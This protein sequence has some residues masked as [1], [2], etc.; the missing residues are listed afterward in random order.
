M[1]SISFVPAH[2]G[3]DVKIFEDPFFKVRIDS[4][5]LANKIVSHPQ[6]WTKGGTN[7]GNLSIS[8]SNNRWPV[9]GFS[10]AGYTATLTKTITFPRAGFYLVDLAT[11]WY[12]T[13]TAVLT[14]TMDGVTLYSQPL[15][16]RYL[17]FG[18][19]HLQPRWYSAGSHTFVISLTGSGWVGHLMVYPITRYEGDN[20][21]N[22]YDNKLNIKTGTF[23][24]NGVSEL[25]QCSLTVDMKE[26]YWSAEGDNQL[27]IK[28]MD[29]LTLWLGETANDTKAMFGGY[30]GSTEINPGDDTLNITGVDRLFDLKRHTTTQTYTIGVGTGGYPSVYELGRYL[31]TTAENPIPTDGIPYVFGLY[32]DF[33]VASDINTITSSIWAVAQDDTKG[34]PATCLKVTKTGAGSAAYVWLHNDEN[35]PYDLREYP[36]LNIGYQHGWS[37]TLP[38]DMNIGITLYLTDEL[39]GDAVEYWL[40]WQGTVP[41]NNLGDVPV[42]GGGPWHS[43]NVNLLQLVEPLVGS[44]NYYVTKIRIY[45]P[46]TEARTVS[47]WFDQIMAYHSENQAMSYSATDMNNYYDVLN[48]LC[49][50]TSHI[51]YIIP[52]DSRPEDIMVIVPQNSLVSGGTIDEGNNLIEISNIKSD[53][54]GDNMVNYLGGGWTDTSSTP[55]TSYGGSW[56][57]VFDYGTISRIDSVEGATNSNVA[58]KYINDKLSSDSIPQTGF[59]ARVRGVPDLTPLQYVT[60]N[61][62]KWRLMGDYPIKSITYN[63]DVG[64]NPTVSTSVDLGRPGSA[65]KNFVRGIRGDFTVLNNRTF[66]IGSRTI[67]Y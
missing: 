16:D 37:S 34:T 51:A 55:Q 63:I 67:G 36:I 20:K 4:K 54:I 8:Y 25:N 23:T 56:E 47:I 11:K 35:N 19:I 41:S 59:S 22:I 30:V 46:N 65:W 13:H 17:H 14:I 49:T 9:I 10:S 48:D 60:C 62:P 12:P 40:H 61:I 57:S 24:A 53:P 38:M 6:D 3:E 42:G 31:S 1:S 45:G 7:P 43:V 2:H 5:D 39:P 29:H 15:A 21:G 52:G 66:G 26:E 28:F 33:G 18:I 50:K 44:D 27:N 58:L 32:K 64:G